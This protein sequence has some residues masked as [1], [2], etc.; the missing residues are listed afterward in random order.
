MTPFNTSTVDVHVPDDKHID[1]D[2]QARHG[3]P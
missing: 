1:P 3:S 2:A